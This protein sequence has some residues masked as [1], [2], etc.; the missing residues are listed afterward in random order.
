MSGECEIVK[1]KILW[2]NLKKNE[3]YV[4]TMILDP[5]NS[6]IV[7]SGIEETNTLPGKLL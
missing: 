3:N 7:Q 1:K 4:G 6:S 5:G 2:D